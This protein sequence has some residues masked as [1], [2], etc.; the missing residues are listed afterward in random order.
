GVLRGLRLPRRRL[1]VA[2]AGGYGQVLIALGVFGLAAMN[3][4][5]NTAP[6]GPA[7]LVPANLPPL[8][9]LLTRY[10]VRYAFADYWLA[11]R[12]TFETRETTLVS[13][14]YVVRDPDI[15]ARVR[16][17]PIPDFLFLAA[18]RSLPI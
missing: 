9:Q 18:S 13:P 6:S 2:C 17:A 4:S 15:D 12:T 8:D 7:V 14:T 10:H 5:G 16:A 1:S 3:S 11:Y